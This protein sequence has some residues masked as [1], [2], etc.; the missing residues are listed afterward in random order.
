MT[1]MIADLPPFYNMQ[2]TEEGGGL[3]KNAHLYNDLSSQILQKVVNYFN[4]GI[5]MPHAT[6]AE[7][8]AHGTDKKVTN[9]TIW[10][11]TSM[12]VLQVKIADGTIETI[13]SIP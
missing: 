12:S 9:G 4:V 3:T 1:K 11:N 8:S 7:I 6:T 10:F 2:Y 5:P 13:Q